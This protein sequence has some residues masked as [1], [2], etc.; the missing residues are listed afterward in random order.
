VPIA[1]PGVV[2]SAGG[3]SNQPVTRTHRLPQNTAV[4]IG[5]SVE[6]LFEPATSLVVYEQPLNERMRTFL[7]LEFLYSQMLYHSELPG[8]WSTRAAV[9]SLLEALAITQRGD[10]RGDVIKELEHH[11]K[12]L[13]EFQAKPGV[14][15]GRLRTVM[16]NLLRLRSELIGLGANYLQPLRD[17]EFLNAIKHRSAIPGGTCEFDL[18]DY[19]FW[20]SRDPE[21]RAASF[22][23]WLELLRPLCDGVL[24]ILWV[25]RQNARPKQESAPGGIY[26]IAFERENPIQLLRIALPADSDLFP[27]ISGSHHRCSLRF[28]SWSDITQRPVQAEH[29]VSFVLTCCT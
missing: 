20:L 26:Q 11:I 18:P 14:D 8:S 25:T 12:A 27:E 3:D 4:S 28:L 16:S 24:E 19:S 6:P 10:A 1:P 9:S 7:R 29:D 21:M 15:P 13:N 23:Q 5:A 2:L 22:N 17:S